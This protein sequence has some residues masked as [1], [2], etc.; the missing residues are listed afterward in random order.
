M[1][2]GKLATVVCALAIGGAAIAPMAAG[3]APL[4]MPA[5]AVTPSSDVVPAQ[6][7]VRQT[8]H[9]GPMYYLN[10]PGPAAGGY[11]GGYRHHHRDYHHY[12]GNDLL[13]PFALG[14]IAGGVIAGPTYVSPYYERRVVPG[15]SGGSAHVRWCY[16]R[17]RSYR[18]SD[19]TFQPYHGPRQ[20]CWSPYS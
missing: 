2:Y 20:Q 16:N 3:A 13:L 7:I 17:Y 1:T 5:A 10:G 14:A 11:Y 15:Y 12:R 4:H 6:F 8:P 9:A 18:A 19:N